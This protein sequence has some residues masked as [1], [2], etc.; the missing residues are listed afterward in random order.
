MKYLRTKTLLFCPQL[1]LYSP[2]I[3]R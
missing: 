3:C 2:T 1:C